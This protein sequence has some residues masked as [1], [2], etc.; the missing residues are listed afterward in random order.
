MDVQPAAANASPIRKRC[1]R[2]LA[3]GDLQT[4]SS[5]HAPYRFDENGKL[6]AGPNPN[7]KQVA[8]GLPGLEVRL[9]LL[10]DA[11]V[12]KGRLGLEKFVE[13]TATAPAKIYNL[14]PRKGSIAV[15][16]D[17]DIAI[18]D[19]AR[20]VTLSDAMMHDLT[21][22][23]PYAGRTLRGWP[24]TVLSRGRVVVADGKRMVEAG[25]GRFL[26]RTGGEAA[27]PIGRLVAD[28][29]PEDEFRRDVAVSGSTLK[30][31]GLRH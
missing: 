26:A 10:F 8:N 11:M 30:R 14:H 15:G 31:G 16:A 20:E 13:L 17:A 21:G 29:D 24:V 6:R 4:I 1:G 19:P 22:Y 23:T 9:P 5:D 18:W 27:K 12:S 28:M 3:L 25:S 2:R 7:F